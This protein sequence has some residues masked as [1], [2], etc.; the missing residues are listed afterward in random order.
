[1]NAETRTKAANKKYHIDSHIVLTLQSICTF[2]IQIAT[3]FFYFLLLYHTTDF[4]DQIQESAAFLP[5][6]FC[7]LY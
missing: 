3:H 6:N 1:M 2:T 4:T 7:Q 5:Q